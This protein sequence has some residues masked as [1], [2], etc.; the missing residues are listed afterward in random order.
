MTFYS[1]Y[2]LLL[3]PLDPAR[4]GLWNYMIAEHW[5][6][7]FLFFK[8]GWHLKTC[9]AGEARYRPMPLPWALC[10]REPCKTSVHLG[11]GAAGKREHHFFKKIVK[12]AACAITPQNLTSRYTPYRVHKTMICVFKK[13][14]ERGHSESQCIADPKAFKALW[15]PLALKAETE[16]VPTN[17][18]C[19]GTHNA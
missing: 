15:Q 6:F 5:P 11:D 3:S 12:F 2:Y 17:S 13:V 7:S 1:P 4:K 18:F 14:P 10:L 9:L 8:L 19:T 16:K